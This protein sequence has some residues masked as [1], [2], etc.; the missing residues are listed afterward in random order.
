MS[1]ETKMTEEFMKLRDQFASSGKKNGKY[2]V[3][4][5]QQKEVIDFAIAHA[6]VIHPLGMEYYVEGFNEFKHCVCDL[7][8]KSCPC[9]EAPQEVKDNGHCLC[10]LFWRD[11]QTYMTAKNLIRPNPSNM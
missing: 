3:T 1:K 10:H 11:Y 7:E 5:P 2:K 8:R 9:A 4:R 6:C